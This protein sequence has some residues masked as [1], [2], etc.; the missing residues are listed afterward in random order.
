[1]KTIYRVLVLGLLTMALT[2]VT[3]TSLFAQDACADVEGKQVVYKKFTD[4]YASKENAQRQLAI[5]AGNEYIEKYGSCADDKDIV[6]YLN[7]SIPTLKA[8]IEAKNK[9]DASGCK[10]CAFHSF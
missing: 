3:A 7:K 4:N 1:M 8:A 10:K 5:D 2:A 6:A 9:Q